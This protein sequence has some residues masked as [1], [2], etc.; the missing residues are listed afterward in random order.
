MENISQEVK[1]SIQRNLDTIE[2][3][4]NLNERIAIEEWRKRNNNVQIGDTVSWQEHQGK[5]NGILV[6][7]S[8]WVVNSSNI[9]V[10]GMVRMFS[11]NSKAIGKKIT[12]I[13]S[14]NGRGIMKKID[15]IFSKEKTALIAQDRFNYY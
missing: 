6:H 5:R 2:K 7:I 10:R 13:H 12:S 11:P 3:L 15:D 9:S 14:H 8:P 1:N 4:N